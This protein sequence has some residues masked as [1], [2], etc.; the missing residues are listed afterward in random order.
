[1]IGI[2]LFLTLALITFLAISAYYAHA[3]THPPRQAACASPSDLGFDATPVEFPSR[4]GITLRGYWI[5]ASRARGTVVF[6]HGYRG[7]CSPDLEYAAWLTSAGYNLLYFDHRA[8]GLSD[9][10]LTT[11]GFY[12]TRDLL[13]AIDFLKSRGIERVGVLGFSMG[14]SVALQT[15]PLTEAIRCVVADC[16]F[17]NL[18]TLITHHEPSFHIPKFFAPVAASLVVAFASLEARCNLFAHSP[19]KSIGLISPRPVLIIQAG[20]DQLVPPSETERLYAAAKAPKELWLVEGAAHRSVDK[21]VR[22]EYERRVLLFLDENLGDSRPRLSSPYQGEEG[23]GSAV[24][25]R[26]SSVIA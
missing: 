8:H 19:E 10:T 9:G 13:G 23:R 16:T 25:R 3:L 21:L 5:P 2:V 22:A 15:A 18:Y 24:V 20:N 6:S 26:P 11:L 17:A 1:M 14:G 4:D 12:E 7:D